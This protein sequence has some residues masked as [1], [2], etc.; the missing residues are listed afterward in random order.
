M[1]EAR[2]FNVVFPTLRDYVR[3]T[4]VAVLCGTGASPARAD[5]NHP[6]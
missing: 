5:H 1:S 6:S 3:N 4:K 2:V